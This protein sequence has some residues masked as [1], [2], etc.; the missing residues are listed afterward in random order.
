MAYI[1]GVVKYYLKNDYYFVGDNST[2]QGNGITDSSFKGEIVIKDK[3]GNIEVREIGQYFFYYC[4]E[5]TKI[6]LDAKLINIHRYAFYG[7]I[8]LIYIN[9]TESVTFIGHAYFHLGPESG[10]VIDLSMT[11]EFNE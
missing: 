11:V 10:A 5:L 4:T 9:I 6:T 2:T 1:D 3:I 7:C 8:S